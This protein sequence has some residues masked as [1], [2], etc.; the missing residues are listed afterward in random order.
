M[1]FLPPP[2]PKEVKECDIIDTQWAQLYAVHANRISA[3]TAAVLAPTPISLYTH[4]SVRREMRSNPKPPETSPCLES[5][6][7]HSFHNRATVRSGSTMGAATASAASGPWTS[8]TSFSANSMAVPGPR[9][10]TQRHSSSTTTRACMQQS[11]TPT[12]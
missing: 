3:V 2:G 5:R 8:S 1:P 9:E 12:R 11:G 6:K 7:L 10:V 4:A